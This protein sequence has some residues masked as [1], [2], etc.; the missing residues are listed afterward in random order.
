MRCNIELFDK[1]KFYTFHSRGWVHRLFFL[2]IIC[3]IYIF[4]LETLQKKEYNVYCYIRGLCLRKIFT[5]VRFVNMSASRE[6]RERA[7]MVSEQPVKKETKKKKKLSEGWI[8]A[9]SVILVVA[10]V[11]GTVLGIRYYQQNQTVLTAGGKDVSVKEF[12]YF[13]NGVVNSFGSNASYLGIDSATP[14]D[15]QKIDAEAVPMMS[16]MGLDSALLDPYKKADGS[17]DV[18]WA[19][20]FAEMAKESAVQAYTIYQAATEAGFTVTDEIQQSIDNELMN[21][22]LYASIYG[23]DTDSFIENTYGRGC[24][25]ENYREYLKVVNVASA[26]A[27]QLTYTDAEVTARYEKNPENYDVVSYLV[28]TIKATDFMTQEEIDASKAAE[29][30]TKKPN[31]EAM[32]EAKTAAEA[33]EKDFDAT[34]D[35]VTAY[36]DVTKANINLTIEGAN[37]W[38]FET[39][40]PGDVKLFEDTENETYYVVKLIENE[41]YATVNALMI[42]IAN[43]AE[44]AAEVSHEGHD[45]GTDEIPAAELSAAD[46][47]KA[48]QDAL[49]ADSSEENFRKLAA[50]GHNDSGTLELTDE[51][52]STVLSNISKEAL[53]WI[54][55]GQ[56]KGAYATFETADGTFVLYYTGEGK[57]FRTCSVTTTLMRE[58]M[59]KVTEEALLTCNYDHD[60]AMNGGVGLVLGTQQG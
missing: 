31:T 20:F 30:E 46:S 47:L 1:S 59:E 58:W 41:N 18:T 34:S 15:E 44:D 21:T 12:N 27:A 23:Y 25:E 5:I 43:D 45:H 39:A 11:F 53:L 52:Y 22:Q 36:A 3:K 49:A 9:I 35:K 4:P 55:E 42:Y 32:A 6:R 26:Y 24:N 29:D 19:G 2:K 8:L 51:Y 37:E 56:E 48:V 17:Y 38:L 7:R 50:E 54:T 28:Y 14:L 57:A 33:M 10:V 40:K 60:A 13:Y 16:L